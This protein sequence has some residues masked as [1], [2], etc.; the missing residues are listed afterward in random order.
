MSSEDSFAT[1]L[2]RRYR[3]EALGAIRGRLKTYPEDFLVDELP[4]YA[5]SGEGRFLFVRIEKR[6]LTTFQ[7]IRLLARNLGLH[8]RHLGYA[9][10]KDARAV[11]T[12]TISI[13]DRSPTTVRRIRVQGLRF[14]DIQRHHESIR[15][16]HLLGNRFHIRLREIEAKDRETFYRVLEILKSEGVPN[17][18]GGQR[19]GFKANSQLMGKALLEADYESFLSHF[20]GRPHPRE[21]ETCQTARRAFEAGDYERAVS[22]F[23]P[24]FPNEAKAAAMYYKTEGDAFLAH[25]A[26][27]RKT[28]QFFVSAYQ[29][30]LFNRFLNE[31][32]DSMN[33]LELGDLV[34]NHA[35]G[36]LFSV[37]D[38]TP[39][40]K[41]L[42][43]FEISIS[44]PIFGAF[45]KK[46]AG[47]PRRREESLLRCEGVEEDDFLRIHG[48]VE[49]GARRTV[50]FPIWDLECHFGRNE[51]VL[52][53]SL[54]KGC[55]ATA[56]FDE[57]FKEPITVGGV[58]R[59]KSKKSS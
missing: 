15:V 14:L 20:L 39:W 16:G 22:G 35:T 23:L 28:R 57:L 33:I 6:G 37:F 27:P 51:A 3:T 31:R 55:Y 18:F 24:T 12:Q 50:R 56:I 8:E 58:P 36:E 40:T 38:P 49:R 32:L 10:L 26:V 4:Q 44:G 1:D 46:G 5:P 17:Y 25:N 52:S 41:A 45:M 47:E 48:F 34:Q 19:F 53:F 42:H 59:Q 13:P 54:P 7:V 9:G 21:D 2:R 29:S 30:L 11:T 43:R